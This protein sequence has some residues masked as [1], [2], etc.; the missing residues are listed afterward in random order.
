MEINKK[1]SSVAKKIIGILVVLG[2]ITGMMCVL[3][4]M[5]YDVMS[6]YCKSLQD[7]VIGL[8]TAS[9]ADAAVLAEDVNYL[10]ERIDIK[11]RGTYIFNIFLV[12]LAMIVTAIAILFSLK[13]IVAPTKKVSMTLA[14][15]VTSIQNGEG[16]L[17]ARV[18]VSSNDEIGQI[19]FGINEF[20]ELLQDNM[21]IMRQSADKLQASIDVVTDKVETSNA[22]V[23]NVSSST[24]ELAASMEE[25]AATIQELTLKSKDVLDQANTISEDAE[26]GMKGISDLRE[27]VIVTC[28]KLESNKQTTARVIDEI[29]DALGSAVEESKRVNNIQE[30]SQGILDIAEQTN[31]LALNA[32]IEAARAGEA[33]KGFAVVADEIRVLADNSQQS[34]SGIQEISALVINAVNKLVD[35]A[36]KMLQFMEGSVVKDYDSFVE[37]MNQYQQDTESLNEMITSFSSEASGMVGTMQHMNTG[38]NDMAT[39]IGESAH[40]VTSVAMDASELV[41]TIVDIQNETHANRQVSEELIAVVNRFKKL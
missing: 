2:M 30:L 31:L 10:F 9:D 37:I 38:M 18:K 32:S 15:I 14:E 6:D 11:I 12:A 20:V 16:D 41:E 19:T 29:Q 7:K 33:G 1:K 3:N 13:M 4:L 8:Q 26:R 17:T 27:R 25:V 36:N 28:T 22:S 40:A 21:F 24:E 34:A 5:A 35:N 39:N 23:T